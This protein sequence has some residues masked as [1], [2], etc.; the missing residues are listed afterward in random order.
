MFLGMRVGIPMQGAGGLWSPY[1]PALAAL[2]AEASSSG[3]VLDFTRNIAFRSGTQSTITGV[4]GWTYTRSGTRFAGD[5]ALT[6][7]GANVPRIVPGSG[8]RVTSGA[9]NLVL[10]SGN[11][12][13]TTDWAA[14]ISGTGVTPTVTANFASAPDGTT[15]AARL[16]LSLAGGTSTADISRVNQS[17]A[18]STATAYVFSV[19]LRSNDGNT[20]TCHLDAT[21]VGP[22]T[23]VTVTPT[24]QRFQIT[25]TS[26][27]T[28]TQLRI[29]LRGGQV[30]TNSNTADILAWGAQLETGSTATDYVPTTTASA[31]AGADAASVTGLTFSGAH[32]LIAIVNS[33]ADTSVDRRAA[34]LSDGTAAN[35][36]LFQGSSTVS[37]L[38]Q[39]GS[40]SQ[41]SQSLGSSSTGVQRYA[42]AVGANN[43]NGSLNG[44]VSTDDTTLTLPAGTLSTLDIGQAFGGNHIGGNVGLLAVLP[45]RISNAELAAT[46]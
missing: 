24:W 18:I 6:S 45:R 27:S 23:Q 28:A 12:G 46:A 14:G 16:Q 22:Q 34:C 41:M 3:L 39:S 4:S 11:L 17:V 38:V 5:S 35:F 9:T 2:L 19:W 36:S 8:I 43:G 37:V 31:T 32:S 7:F 29:G 25:G 13:N 15:T 40:V 30:P 10:S 1:S 21:T 44:S 20:Y 26:S 42:L 33:R